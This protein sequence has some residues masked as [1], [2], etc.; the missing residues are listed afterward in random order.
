M[1]AIC[2]EFQLSA[3]TIIQRYIGMNQFLDQFQLLFTH[4][5]WC[6]TNHCLN[7]ALWRLTGLWLSPNRRNGRW[8]RSNTLQPKGSVQ[9]RSGL[10]QCVSCFLKVTS[11]TT[12]HLEDIRGGQWGRSEIFGSSSSSVCYLRVYI[13]TDPRAFSSPVDAD[14]RAAD[15]RRLLCDTTS[16]PKYS[17]EYD[18][19]TSRRRRWA[20]H[21][22]CCAACKSYWMPRSDQ[23][24]SFYIRRTFQI[25]RYIFRVSN[26]WV[27]HIRSGNTRAPA[28]C[29]GLSPP[30]LFRLFVAFVPLPA[31]HFSFAGR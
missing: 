17:G 4:A 26:G 27:F 5:T 11:P 23:S 29:L 28:A 6:V 3:A 2:Q 19:A 30:K 1:H 21:R 7:P 15:G 14:L 13:D 31:T 12:G 22:T 25:A 24:S 18:R 10:I 8:T 9:T 20:S 16:N